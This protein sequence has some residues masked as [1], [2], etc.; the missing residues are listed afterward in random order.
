MVALALPGVARHTRLRSSNSSGRQ[1]EACILAIPVLDPEL[2]SD[3]EEVACHKLLFVGRIAEISLS[4]CRVLVTEP[5][6]RLWSQTPFNCELNI[7]SL[8]SIYP[9]PN[10]SSEPRPNRNYRPC[11]M[12]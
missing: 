1:Q 6:I 3:L 8:I 4:W 9:S 11:N 7:A 10:Q 2:I 5:Q 12:T